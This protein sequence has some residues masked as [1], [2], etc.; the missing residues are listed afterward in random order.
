MNSLKDLLAYNES[1]RLVTELHVIT[2]NCPK[3]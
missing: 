1:I 2:R 3:Y